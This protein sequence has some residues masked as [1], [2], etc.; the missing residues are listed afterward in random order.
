MKRFFTLIG[1]ISTLF[2]IT[3]LLDKSASNTSFTPNKNA[4]AM[5]KKIVKVSVIP[6][7]NFSYD[8]MNLGVLQHLDRHYTYDVIPEQLINGLLFQGIHE[9]PKG[10]VIKFNLLTPATVYF[11]GCAG[12]DGGFSSILE[13]LP[14]WS[15]S[16]A[17]PQYDIYNGKHGLF[18]NMYRYDADIGLHSIPAST[19]NGACFNMVFQNTD[20]L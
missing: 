16:S 11:I 10:T 14:N 17:F 4:I 2:I 6:N 3:S 18:M 13:K 12:A 19:E 20:K 8:F 15:R 1:L 7:F 5:A 9:V